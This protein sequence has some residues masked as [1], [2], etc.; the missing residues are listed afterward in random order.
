M[1]IFIKHHLGLGDCIVANG[2]VRKTRQDHK[3]A[4]V[5]ISCKSNN[6]SNVKFMYRDDPQI[7]ILVMNDH[8]TNHHLQ[9][10]KYDKVI[11]A[12]FEQGDIYNYAIHGDDA[13][14]LQAGFDPKIR[15][16]HFFV[17][18]DMDKE[19]E[20]YNFFMKKINSKEYY[21]FHEKPDQNIT[22]NRQYLPDQSLPVISAEPNYNFFNLFTTIEKAKEVHV[23]SSCFL[24]LFMILKIN[25]KTFAHMY[26]DR[27]GLTQVVKNNGI[28]I[29]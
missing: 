26:A 16:T 2:M 14:Y 12:H 1:K 3:Q 15:R 22:I 19:I 20:L 24:S 25:H 23:I 7:K 9:T 4:D 29:F 17:Q 8:E 6:L 27:I 28:S 10:N 5:F 11:H 13:F 18:R 21:F